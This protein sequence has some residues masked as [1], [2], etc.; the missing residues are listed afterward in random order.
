VAPRP[1]QFGITHAAS[2]I[3]QREKYLLKHKL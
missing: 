3:A 1:T 2:F